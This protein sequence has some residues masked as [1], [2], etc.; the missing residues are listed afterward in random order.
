MPRSAN[1]A[2]SPPYSS[3]TPVSSLSLFSRR[4]CPASMEFLKA[5]S[6]GAVPMA[7]LYCKPLLGVSHG[8]EEEEG[9][10]QRAVQAWASY[11]T[12]LRLSFLVCKMGI[13]TP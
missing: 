8:E 2:G 4:P 3:V 13:M 5:L 11:A 7:A 12:S 9:L 6:W 10:V 1:L